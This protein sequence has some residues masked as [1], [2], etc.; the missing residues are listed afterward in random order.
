MIDFDYKPGQFSI[1]IVG[2]LILDHSRN[3]GEIILIRN[4]L[5]F[6]ETIGSCD[7][8]IQQVLNKSRPDEYQLIK[9][10]LLAPAL[11]KEN[12]ALFPLSLLHETISFIG[13]LAQQTESTAIEF[14]MFDFDQHLGNFQKLS[15]TRKLFSTILRSLNWIVEGN[16]VVA[17]RILN[18]ALV[19]TGSKF[20]FLGRRLLSEERQPYLQMAAL[21]DISWDEDTRAL[22]GGFVFD[23]LKA[24]FGPTLED[25]SK[26][27]ANNYEKDG[28]GVGLP[29]G[30]PPLVSYLGL[31]IWL[32]GEL[33]GMIGLAG[34]P[35]G[36]SN[37][38]QENC[39]VFL[40]Y[41]SDLP[42][43][44]NPFDHVQ[45]VQNQKKSEEISNH[46]SI[47]ENLGMTFIRLEGTVVTGVTNA[48][49]RMFGCLSSNLINLDVSQS[50][51]LGLQVVGD[52]EWTEISG[53]TNI[54]NFGPE[55]Y[56][57]LKQYVDG[58]TDPI[59]YFRLI[60][61]GYDSF[62]DEGAIYFVRE[63]TTAVRSMSTL[64][65]QA[66][67]AQ[68]TSRIQNNIINMISHEL[69]TPLTSIQ[70][71]VE[72]IEMDRNGDDLQE[73]FENIYKMIGEMTSEM[74]SVLSLGNLHADQMMI[75]LTSIPVAPILKQVISR[76]PS[77]DRGRIH[78]IND[79]TDSTD[80]PSI[81]GVESMLMG[82]L[83]NLLSNAL[84]FSSEMVEIQTAV[85]SLGRIQISVS[86]K[87]IGI[88]KEELETI[89]GPFL[90]AS[91]A[92]RYDGTGVGLTIV[93]LMAEKMGAKLELVSEEFKGTKVKVTFETGE[94]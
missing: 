26:V 67:A 19:L 93:K 65:N 63:I 54:D 88:P 3:Y 46:W 69:R 37:S 77:G 75:K 4:S 25:G 71:S 47:L 60:R 90:R 6:Q 24:L 9:E 11:H 89:F 35:D 76:L 55:F 79:S 28:R 30:N 8:I 70:T 39:R 92:Q 17:T 64:L 80:L 87:G 42:A 48:C 40:S 7:E 81:L 15:S 16:Q 36:Y 13:F 44:L 91:N 27:V 49:T 59:R 83:S 41:L 86:D 5:P 74:E 85:D 84:K 38:T 20:G 10:F 31:P 23:N 14:T 61:S 1:P 58:P 62:S 51:I 32:N 2:K 50:N 52:K 12:M 53:Q 21:T 34:N 56:L 73:N 78:I 68:K 94:I 43:Q 66:H 18:E 22:K 57:I 29:P 82:I 45:H 33:Y 72:F